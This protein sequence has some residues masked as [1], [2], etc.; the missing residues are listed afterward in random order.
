MDNEKEQENKTTILIDDIE[1]VYE[2]M[3]DEQKVI[4]EHITDLGHKSRKAQ[5]ELDQLN[6]AK[7]GFVSMLKESLATQPEESTDS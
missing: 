6:V 4:I 5:L 7:N 3:T 2:D 1:H